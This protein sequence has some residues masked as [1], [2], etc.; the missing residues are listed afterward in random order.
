MTA[1]IL[2]IAGAF[3]VWLACLVLV[4]PLLLAAAVIALRDMAAEA[5]KKRQDMRR[6]EA[7]IA[8]QVRDFARELQE[9]R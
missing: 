5:R 7:R 9:W 6:E 3:G 4:I 8:E 1:V 2:R